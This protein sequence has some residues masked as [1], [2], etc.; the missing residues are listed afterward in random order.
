MEITK[1]ERCLIAITVILVII[2][3]IGFYYDRNS[4]LI[5][6]TNRI[7]FSKDSN[8]KLEKIN[9]VGFLYA[10]QSYEAKFRIVDNKWGDYFNNISKQYG[11]GGGLC[12]YEGYKQFETQALSKNTIVPQPKAD[13]VIWIL[14]TPIDSKTKQN[15]V[16]II[17]T[18]V[19]G[20]A[21]LYIYYSR[22]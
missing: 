16:Y 4:A 17:D 22:T 21:Y 2:L 11:G 5:D 3:A 6:R 7:A 20:N 10:R 9:K 14:G 18:E 8:L 13:A 1:K 19:D 12:G 15:V